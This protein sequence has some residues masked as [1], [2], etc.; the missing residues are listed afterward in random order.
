MSILGVADTDL[1][2]APDTAQAPDLD[3]MASIDVRVRKLLATLEP[4]VQRAGVPFE[5]LR[6][7]LKGR[8]GGACSLVELSKC[9]RRMGWVPRRSWHLHGTE[10]GAIVLWYPPNVE[11]VKEMA[12]ARIAGKPGKIPRWLAYAKR[13]AQEEGYFF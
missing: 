12:V 3:E 5:Y 1:D 6:V 13:R 8:T 11:P 10:H 2:H 7:R 9:L 4:S